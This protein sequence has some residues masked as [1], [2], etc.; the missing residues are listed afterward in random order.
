MKKVFSPKRTWV[1]L[2]VLLGFKCLCFRSSYERLGFYAE[3]KIIFRHSD[4]ERT[5]GNLNVR[6]C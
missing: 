3:I 4:V 2:V 5:P 6:L 1:E